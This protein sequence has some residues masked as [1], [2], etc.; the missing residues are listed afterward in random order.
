MNVELAI[1]NGTV[2]DPEADATYEADLG[3]SAGKIVA[4]S[5]QRGRLKARETVDARG[6]LVTPGLVDSH[7]HVYQHVSSGSLDPDD[8]GVRQGVRAVVDAGSF[9][10][11]N[12]AGFNEYVV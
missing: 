2:V 3:V 12:A 11:G 9:G 5:R 4:V 6:L 8:I 1:L 10:P 7:V